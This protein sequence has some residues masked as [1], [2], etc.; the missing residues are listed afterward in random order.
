M[1]GTSTAVC[2]LTYPHV[3]GNTTP[4]SS[5]LRQWSSLRY[6]PVESNIMY[7]IRK[8][9][10]TEIDEDISSFLTMVSLFPNVSHLSLSFR[11]IQVVRFPMSCCNQVEFLSISGESIQEIDISSDS[12]NKLTAFPSLSC[13]HLERINMGPRSLR[14]AL[15]IFVEGIPSLESL[16]FER[17]SCIACESLELAHLPSLTSVVIGEGAFSSVNP[18][19]YYRIPSRR[20]RRRIIG[21]GETS[22]CYKFHSHSIIL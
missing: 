13:D 4:L 5:T 8:V 17:G 3:G 21:G 7:S 22:R 10:A 2:I 14:S 9:S 19:T 12:L 18:S 1:F 11:S 16:R 6:K 20:L 15:S